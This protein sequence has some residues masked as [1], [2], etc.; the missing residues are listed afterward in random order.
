MKVKFL[1]LF[2]FIAASLYSQDNEVIKD[3]FHQFKYPNGAVSSEGMIRNGKPDGYW[4]SYYI[5]GVLKSEGK[6]T[7]YL[8]D[9]IWL[10]YNQRGD[11]IEKINYILGKKNG[12][13]LKF[14]EDPIKGMYLASK[15]LYAGDLK[16]SVAI[17]YYPEGQ[18][19]Q[20]I[21]YYHGKKDGLSKEYD[22]D[23]KIITLMEYKND[24]LINREKI[25]KTDDK[26]L[27]QGKWL[28]F[29]LS[30]VIKTERN[31]KDDLLHGYYKEYNDKGKLILT[32]LYDNGKVTGNDLS[33]VPE[34]EV[35]KKYNDAG[36]LIYSGPYKEGTPVG[37]HREYNDDG[38]IK[39]AK[40]YGENGIVLSEGIVDEAGN[41]NGP[42]KDYSASGDLTAEGQYSENKRAGIWKFYGENKKVEQVGAYNNGKINGTWRWYY[43]D[44]ELLREEEYYQGRRDGNYT[45]YTRD[46]N[47]ITQGVYTDGERNGEWTYNNGDNTEKGNY[48]VGLKDGLWK[49]FYPDGKLRF[50]GEFIQGN[51][52]GHHTFFYENGKVMEERYYNNGMR[53][54]T[55]KKFSEM[56]EVILTITYRDDI[57]IFVNGVKVNL[58]ESTQKS[59]K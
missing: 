55:W 56:G 25:N 24:F 35:V 4:K 23:G 31:Y 14:Q 26:G 21:P 37:I 3:G 52:N 10:F 32:L 6:R 16:E 41:K 45:E 39:N 7:S 20:T 51:P 15:E 27:K 40:I 13:Y 11:T 34:I 50:K 38:T 42:W 53:T 49:A 36:R 46:G 22:R 54:K 33:N 18:I 44:G 47:V 5:T 9:S 29:Y 59:I 43:P 8:L 30:G 48:I 12:Y 28:D 19:R 58:P 2:L 1:I 17:F 57:E